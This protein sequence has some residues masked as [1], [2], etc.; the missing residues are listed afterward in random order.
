MS[1]ETHYMREEANGGNCL[2]AL[3]LLATAFAIG[4]LFGAILF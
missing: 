1:F 2:I 3:A 4:L